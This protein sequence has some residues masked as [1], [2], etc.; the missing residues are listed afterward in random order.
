MPTRPGFAGTAIERL[1]LPCETTEI[2]CARVS[3]TSTEGAFIKDVT[4]IGR[5]KHEAQGEPIRAP[6]TRCIEHSNIINI[7]RGGTAVNTR[8]LP[9]DRRSKHQ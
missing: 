5:F 7:W 2:C 6:S 9:L 4:R 3:F 8:K 1:P